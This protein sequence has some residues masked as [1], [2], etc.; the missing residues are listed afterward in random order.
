MCL[1]RVKINQCYSVLDVL[2]RVA[3]FL[4]LFLG[5]YIRTVRYV[6]KVAVQILAVDLSLISRYLQNIVSYLI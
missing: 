5:P 1:K 3:L 2:Y 6:Q 4:F